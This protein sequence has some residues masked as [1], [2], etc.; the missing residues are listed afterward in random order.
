LCNEFEGLASAQLTANGGSREDTGK[1]GGGGRIAVA[2]GLNPQQRAEL[3]A[4]SMPAKVQTLSSY[5]KFQGQTNVVGGTS[6]GVPSGGDGTV[7]WLWMQP[8]SGT[9][10][11]FR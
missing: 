6:S 9:I 4:G 11:T 10:F 5:D 8:A 3:L 2:I 7:V 1:G